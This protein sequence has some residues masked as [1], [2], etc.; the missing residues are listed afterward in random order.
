[1]VLIILGNNL[2]AR[3]LGHL[4]ILRELT[5]GAPWLLAQLGDQSPCKPLHKSVPTDPKR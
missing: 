5:D 3:H 1:M 2:A 4:D